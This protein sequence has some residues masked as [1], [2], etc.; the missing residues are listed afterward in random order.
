MAEIDDVMDKCN[1]IK[2]K[3]DEIKTVVDGLVD[4]IE[5]LEF[6]SYKICT[7]CH[8]DGTVIPSHDLAGPTPDPITC[9][10]CSG[11]G[12]IRSGSTMEKD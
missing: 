12:R 5:N 7:M 9:P 8:G 2:E 11:E 3:V 1:D 4:Q 10:G 6:I